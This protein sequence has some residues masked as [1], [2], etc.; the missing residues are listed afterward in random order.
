MPTP[1]HPIRRLPGA[2]LVAVALVG[3]ACRAPNQRPPVAIGPIE[4]YRDSTDAIALRVTLLDDRGAPTSADGTLQVNIYQLSTDWSPLAGRAV[5]RREPLHLVLRTV[6]RTDFVAVKV[7]TG[8]ARHET[9]LYNVGRIPYGD[10]TRHP[11]EANGLA[12][13]VFHTA[14]GRSLRSECRFLF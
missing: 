4:V 11:T 7:G 2:V 13:L 8:G 10:F 3:G 9:V 6:R 1:R 14:D 5:G 12:Q